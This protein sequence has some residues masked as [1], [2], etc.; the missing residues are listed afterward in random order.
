[1]NSS[2]SRNYSGKG[3]RE[4]NHKVPGDE[5]ENW[6]ITHKQKNDGMKLHNKHQPSSYHME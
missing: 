5:R 4:N 1:M 2:G 6:A 3:E